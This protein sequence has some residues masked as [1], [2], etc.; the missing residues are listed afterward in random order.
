MD[1]LM[2]LSQSPEHQAFTD[3]AG[4]IHPPHGMYFE[5]AD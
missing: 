1:G 2:A 5:A 3:E 4:V